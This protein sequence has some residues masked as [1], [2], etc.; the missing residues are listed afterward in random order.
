MI[1]FVA[2]SLANSLFFYIYADGK[3]RYEFNPNEP[4][5]FK[6]LFISMRAG[7]IA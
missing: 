4:Y 5:S 3:K 6:T 7:T 1:N 2:G